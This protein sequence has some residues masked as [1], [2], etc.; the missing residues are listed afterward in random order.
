MPVDLA[1]T[2]RVWPWVLR[3]DHDVEGWARMRPW[4][5]QGSSLSVCTPAEPATTVRLIRRTVYQWD[6]GLSDVRV[7]DLDMAA[8]EELLAVMGRWLG[9]AVRTK[10]DLARALGKD[11]QYRPT[12]FLLLTESVSAASRCLDDAEEIREWIVK[13][14]F[15]RGPGVVVLHRGPASV[16]RGSSSADFGWPVGLASELLTTSQSEA[17]PSYL[18]LRVA[19]ETAGH[20]DDAVDCASGLSQ[21]PVGDD[22]GCER[23]LNA[24][25]S[26]RLAGLS[27]AAQHELRTQCLDRARRNVASM[28]VLGTASYRTTTAPW[29]ARALLLGGVD[30]AI[31]RSLRGEL[32]CRPLVER[33]LHACFEIE[34]RLRAQLGGQRTDLPEGHACAAFGR[35]TD[36]AMLSQERQLYPASHPSP[37]RDAW[38]FASLGNLLRAI[39]SAMPELL[40]IRNALSHG[41][42]AGWAALRSVR[43][44]FRTD[45]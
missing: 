27:P 37:P 13:L 9:V 10:G 24:F 17:W 16:A 21:L 38:D 33:L 45:G 44:M 1:L 28:T 34:A 14:D 26:R 12:V 22:D 3:C 23:S 20:L 40:S 30:P 2:G 4:A 6:A 19:W 18:H 11:L 31:H 42:Y 7:V 5:A 36:V 43:T 35:Y 32:V 39:G 41:H 8:D 15:E 29:I 25:A